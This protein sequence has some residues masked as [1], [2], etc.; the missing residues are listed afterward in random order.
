MLLFARPWTTSI[1]FV[2]D[3]W[4][5]SSKFT[6]SSVSIFVFFFNVCHFI[7]VLVSVSYKVWGKVDILL[8]V[9]KDI[10][11]SQQLKYF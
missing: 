10:F 11:F 4:Q 8:G 3:Y 9:S 7:F 1:K 6:D 5:F 2:I